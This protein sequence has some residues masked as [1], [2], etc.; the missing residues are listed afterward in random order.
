MSREFDKFLEENP[1]VKFG[2]QQHC[3]K[4]AWEA[5][6]KEILKVIISHKAYLMPD[7]RLGYNYVDRE[8]YQ[9]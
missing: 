2:D 3:A 9:Y 6:K 5:C 1:I 8:D 4:L 7:N